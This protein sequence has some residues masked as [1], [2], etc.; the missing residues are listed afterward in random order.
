MAKMNPQGAI[1]SRNEN[2]SKLFSSENC[3]IFHPRF[4][5]LREFA[6]RFRAEKKPGVRLGQQRN[7]VYEKT[8]ITT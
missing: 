6:E 8:N 4:D 1:H 3:G 7:Q 2:L 5:Y